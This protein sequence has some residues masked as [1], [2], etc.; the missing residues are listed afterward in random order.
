[1]APAVTAVLR[2]TGKGAC[3]KHDQCYATY[4]KSKGT[5]DDEFESDLKSA[6]G[7]EYGGPTWRKYVKYADPRYWECVAT[8]TAFASAVKYLPQ[9]NAAYNDAQRAAASRRIAALGADRTIYRITVYTGNVDKGGTSANVYL[10]L[11]GKKGQGPEWN[12]DKPGDQFERGMVDDFDREA[13]SVGDIKQVRI[14]HDN[15]NDGPGWF[16]SKITVLDLRTG[17]MWTFPCNRWL[18]RD[19]D[20]KKLDRTLNAL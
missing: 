12:L 17:R 5:C 14:R 13:K 7:R 8:A 9:A 6:C 16:L 2:K 3:N 10:T 4:G 1:M 20:D 15:S 19:E 18:A 11:I